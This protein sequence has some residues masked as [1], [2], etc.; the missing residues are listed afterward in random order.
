MKVPA[1]FNDGGFD[2]I[3]QGLERCLGKGREGNQ[4][5][6]Q[7]SQ[8]SGGHGQIIVLIHR[9]VQIKETVR[10]LRTAKAYSPFNMAKL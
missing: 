6:R 7:Q 10:F 9:R 1:P 4:R 3:D 5:E 8:E 2:V